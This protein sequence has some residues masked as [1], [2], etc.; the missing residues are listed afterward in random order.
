MLCQVNRAAKLLFEN[1]SRICY[2]N[3]F[4][5]EIHILALLELSLCQKLFASGPEFRVRPSG[6]ARL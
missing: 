5:P 2:S 6:E 4:M 1:L 3:V